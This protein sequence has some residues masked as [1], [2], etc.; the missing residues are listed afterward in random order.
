MASTSTATGALGAQSCSH[1]VLLSS[2]GC[3]QRQTV[4]PLTIPMDSSP[5]G[6]TDG[7][8]NWK[9]TCAAASH[10]FCRF[11]ALSLASNRCTARPRCISDAGDNKFRVC[12]EGDEAHSTVWS[13]G[14]LLS[15]CS[16]RRNRAPEA[17]TAM[18]LESI[19]TVPPLAACV[20]AN[21]PFSI[22]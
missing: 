16:S 3:M 19:A 4:V 18:V 20:R 7:W 9:A 13:D 1:H 21:A 5:S 15:C 22:L 14:Q 12:R 11:S 8:C 17:T 2:H 6:L 10:P